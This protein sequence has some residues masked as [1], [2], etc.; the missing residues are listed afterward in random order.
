[1][2][3]NCHASIPCLTV[4]PLSSL[5][6]TNFL[7]MS[8]SRKRKLAQISEHRGSY[9]TGA[10]DA[11][12]R[13]TDPAIFI[14]AYEADVI[15]GSPAAAARAL[16]IMIDEPTSGPQEI[17]AGDSS[18]GWEGSGNHTDDPGDA[19]VDR[20]DDQLTVDALPPTITQPSVSTQPGSP[21]GCSDLPS[22]AEDTLLTAEEIEDFRREKRRKRIAQNREDRLR[23]LQAREDEVIDPPEDEWGGSDEEPDEPQKSVM[24]RTATHIL[25]SSN[26][27]QLEMR[28]LANHG[29][30]SR[31]AFLRGRWSRTWALIKAKIKKEA[32]EAKEKEER[33]K[34]LGRLMGY[35]GSDDEDSQSKSCKSTEGAGQVE[36]LVGS[37]AMEMEDSTVRGPAKVSADEDAVKEARRARAREWAK[38]RRA[39]KAQELEGNNTKLD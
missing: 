14:V 15:R 38:K 31:F 20:C 8:Q 27:A 12:L 21:S 6:F 26:A 30:D 2:V 4:P 13:E 22:D 35:E 24:R 9:S 25:S 39:S 16:E 10:Q 29:A 17:K 37:Q 19:C 11:Q 32:E 34:G 18:L 5:L 3:G 36:Q 7:L 23:A 1:M 33:E 28:I